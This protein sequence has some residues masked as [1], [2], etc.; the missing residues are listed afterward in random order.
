[1]TYRDKTGKLC[2]GAEDREHGTVQECR[3]EGGQWTLHLADGQRLSLSHVVGVANTDAS[4][5]ILAAWAVR[6][7]GY[8]GEKTF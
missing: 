3:W 5:R 6:A 8:D 7:H 2:G 1:V 4:G